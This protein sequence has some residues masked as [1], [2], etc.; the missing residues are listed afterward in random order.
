MIII[1]NDWK[2]RIGGIVIGTLLYCTGLALI[3][4]FI[5]IYDRL[6]IAYL[7]AGIQLLGITIG[8]IGLIIGEKLK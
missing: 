6:L 4:L 8:V 7:G 3:L 1:S 2:A 5:Y